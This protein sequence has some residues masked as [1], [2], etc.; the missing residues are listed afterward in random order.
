MLTVGGLA[1]ATKRWYCAVGVA[2][3]KPLLYA[4]LFFC[5]WAIT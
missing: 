3:A 5:A 1:M 2:C 4:V